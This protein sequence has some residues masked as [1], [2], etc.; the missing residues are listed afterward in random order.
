MNILS[1]WINVETGVMKLMMKLIGRSWFLSYD[2]FCEKLWADIRYIIDI[3]ILELLKWLYDKKYLLTI[4][5]VCG[6]ELVEILLSYSD[7][8]TLVIVTICCAVCWKSVALDPHS[9]TMIVWLDFTSCSWMSFRI[10]LAPDFIGET[11]EFGEVNVL[12]VV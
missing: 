11:Y 7:V 12:N 8:S 3:L 5:D 10:Q 9:L 2:V 4:V 1:H 6:V